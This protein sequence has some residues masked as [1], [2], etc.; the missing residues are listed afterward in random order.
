MSMAICLLP[1]IGSSHAWGVVYEQNHITMERGESR[2]FYTSLQNMV[3]DIGYDVNVAV[4]D[5]RELASINQTSYNL[6]PDT[7]KQPVYVNLEIPS[8]FEMGSCTAVIRYELLWSGDGQ[9]GLRQEKAVQIFI[10]ID[11]EEPV[12]PEPEPEP[13]PEPEP[14]QESSSRSSRTVHEPQTQEPEPEPAPESNQTI[15]Y[16]EPDVPV[17]DDGEQSDVTLAEPSDVVAMVA[18]MGVP[19]VRIPIEWAIVIGIVA[20]VAYMLLPPKEEEEKQPVYDYQPVY[21]PS[22]GHS[23]HASSSPSQEG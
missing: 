15:T 10:T 13:A 16:P 1:L 4:T 14:E 20:L 6:P 7:L 23:P 17:P 9:V 5:C 3:G 18:E 2:Q 19:P 11:E 21:V 12:E 8:D 22:D